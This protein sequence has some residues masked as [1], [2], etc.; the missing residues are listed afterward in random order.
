MIGQG[1]SA[2]EAQ[3]EVH[4]VVEGV[5][6]AECAYALS[7]KYNVSMPITEAAYK[8]LF[9]KMSPRDAVMS[10]MTR[11]R[12]SEADENEAEWL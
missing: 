8:I 6:A 4:M 7:K 5:F 9:E 10:L 12:K 3:K 11:D 1:M 2:Q